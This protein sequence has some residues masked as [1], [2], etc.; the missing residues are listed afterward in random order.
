M[1]S[2]TLQA[3]AS[4]SQFP[5]KRIFKKWD[6]LANVILEMQNT[7]VIRTRAAT[8]GPIKDGKGDTTEMGGCA[9]DQGARMEMM[10]CEKWTQTNGVCLNEQKTKL[11][12]ELWLCKHK[13]E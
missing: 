8:A 2:N 6:H 1:H 4:S 3:T 7:S 13:V 9:D 5:S 10:R 12:Y 11:I